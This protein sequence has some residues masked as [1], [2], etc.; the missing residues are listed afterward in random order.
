M[1]ALQ[2]SVAQALMAL[3]K[4]ALAYIQAL[5]EVYKLEAVEVAVC[6]LSLVEVVAHCHQ[7]S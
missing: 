1:E 7:G 4:Q 2:V 6:K 5:G 3:D